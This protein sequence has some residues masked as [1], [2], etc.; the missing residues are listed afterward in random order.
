MLRGDLPGRV[1]LQEDAIAAR[2]VLAVVGLLVEVLRRVV[3]EEGSEVLSAVVLSHQK[4]RDQA[5]VD[6]GVVSS[7][8]KKRV[9][10][11]NVRKWEKRE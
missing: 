11:K 3:N 4:V 5:A 2:K 1:G 6:L 10:E 8:E 9:R 7:F